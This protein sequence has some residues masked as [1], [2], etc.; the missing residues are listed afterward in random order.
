VATSPK[1]DVGTDYKEKYGFF[2][3]EDYVFKP[4]AG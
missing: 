3:P 2:V 1:I 4:S